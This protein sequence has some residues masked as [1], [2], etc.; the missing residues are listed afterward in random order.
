MPFSFDSV[1]SQVTGEHLVLHVV[2]SDPFASSVLGDNWEAD[3]L[4]RA[5]VLFANDDILRH[6]HETTSQVA[7]VCCTQSRVGQTLSRTVGRDEVLRNRETLA[8]AGA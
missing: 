4:G 8:V 5:T 6:I 7:G 1:G 2:R 3:S